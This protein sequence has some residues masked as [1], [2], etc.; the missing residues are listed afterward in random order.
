MANLCPAND[1]GE[2]T[3]NVVC[4]DDHRPSIKWASGR[5]LCLACRHEW[6]AVAPIGTW[7]LECPKCDSTKGIFRDPFCAADGDS[8]FRCNC[9]SE[10]LTAYLH[11]GRFNL[12]C[13]NCGTDQTEAVFG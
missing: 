3:G 5:G 4:L 9:G 7:Q 1:T 10:A 6:E 11:K 2:F 12:R 13:M 8:V